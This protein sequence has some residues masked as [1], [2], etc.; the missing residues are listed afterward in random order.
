MS[1]EAPTNL[2]ILSHETRT[3][4]GEGRDSCRDY[5]KIMKRLYG[6]LKRMRSFRAV[7]AEF[8]S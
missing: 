7:A 6:S 1:H 2:L 5:E 8:G 3:E 4:V